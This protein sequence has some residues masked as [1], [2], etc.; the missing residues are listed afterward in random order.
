LEGE[1]AARGFEALFR[2]GGIGV[3][4]AV[5]QVV[6][7]FNDTGQNRLDASGTASLFGWHLD[8][9]VLAFL[10]AVGAEP[11]VDEYDMTPD[12]DTG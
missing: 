9:D 3:G 8:R 11:D 2:A 12:W 7:H 6:R 10:T 1:S 5:L 4:G